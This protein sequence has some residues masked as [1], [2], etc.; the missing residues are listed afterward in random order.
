VRVLLVGCYELGHQPLQVAAPAGILRSRGHDVRAVDLSMQSWDPD[1][2]AWADRIAIS[3]PMHTAMRIARRVIALADAAAPGTPVCAYG[4]YAPMLADVADRVMAGESDQAL[5]DWVDGSDETAVVFLGRDAAT[6]GTP[7]PARDLLP[8]L[9]RYAHLAIAGDERP[10]AYVE[11]SHGCAH[12]CRHCP[13]PVIYDGRIRIVDVDHVVADVAQQVAAGARHVTFGDP[14]FLNGVHHSLR[15]ARAVHERFPDLTFDCT[16]KVEHILRHADVWSELADIGCLFVVSAFESTN[17]AILERL[18][19]GH[20][21]ADEARAVALLRAHGI[22]VRPTWLPFTPWTTLADVQDLLRFVADHDL[23]GNVDPVQ[24]TIRLLIPKGSLLLELPDVRERV[25]PYDDER[26]AYPW[27]ADDPAVDDLQVAL[28]ALV[29]GRLAEGASIP[30]IFRNVC[31]ACG[32]D[33]GLIP[34]GATEGRPRLTEP[35]FC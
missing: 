21:A 31:T 25:G 11:A 1:L 26:G 20:T 32:V 7:L 24:Y 23:V 6:P 10:V 2:A 35:W 30:E 17:D 5:A 15:V 33:P 34:A 4:L 18:D 9:D 14:D 16:V 22:E 8:P 28:A 27:S 29:E 12:R 19:K 13:V 3:V